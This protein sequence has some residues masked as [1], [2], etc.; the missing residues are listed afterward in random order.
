MKCK[1]LKALCF[2]FVYLVVNLKTDV[3]QTKNLKQHFAGLITEN[4]F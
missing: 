2:L 4:L 1:N 3:I